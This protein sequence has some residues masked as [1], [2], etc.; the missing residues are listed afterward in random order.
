MNSKY[1][2]KKNWIMI[3]TLSGIKITTSWKSSKKAVQNSKDTN[4]KNSLLMI[5]RNLTYQSETMWS[6]KIQTIL[7]STISWMLHLDPSQL[8]L[9]NPLSYNRKRTSLSS[10]KWHSLSLPWYY[11][12]ITIFKLQSNQTNSLIIKEE[13]SVSM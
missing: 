11:I 13:P 1:I 6:K 12:V 2:K 9:V 10:Q 5:I 3:L 4:N 7:N 8:R